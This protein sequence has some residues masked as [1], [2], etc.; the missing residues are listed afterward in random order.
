MGHGYSDA[1]V[2]LTG[3]PNRVSLVPDDRLLLANLWK[4]HCV[5]S[6]RPVSRWG[7]RQEGEEEEEVRLRMGGSRHG[8]CGTC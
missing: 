6:V 1:C 5:D 4:P 3:T 2:V 7:W 8:G